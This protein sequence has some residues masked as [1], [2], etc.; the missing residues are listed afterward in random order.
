MIRRVLRVCCDQC[1]RHL[2]FKTR[3]EVEACRLAEKQGWLWEYPGEL[4]GFE[5]HLCEECH[6]KGSLQCSTT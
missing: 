6:K 5:R 4:Y 2:T 3:S 1:E